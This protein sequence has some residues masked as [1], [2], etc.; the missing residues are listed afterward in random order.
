VVVTVMYSAVKVTFQYL[1]LICLTSLRVSE[2]SKA[3]GTQVR[4][5]LDARREHRLS[6]VVT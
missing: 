3:S 5:L 2:V 6:A 1:S 4:R